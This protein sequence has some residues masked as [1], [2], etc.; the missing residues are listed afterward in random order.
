MGDSVLRVVILPGRRRKLCRSRSRGSYFP[1]RRKR[2]NNKDYKRGSTRC[3]R[4]RRRIAKSVVCPRGGKITVGEDVAVGNG[5]ID[6]EAMT[7]EN[8][9]ATDIEYTDFLRYYT[10]GYSY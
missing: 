10:Q 2:Q 3:V 8:G 5:A 1:R 9:E 7:E 4:R 6:K